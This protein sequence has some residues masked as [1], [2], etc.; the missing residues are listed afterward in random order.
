M[1]E[2]KVPGLAALTLKEG[3]IFWIGY[4]GWGNYYP[5]EWWAQKKFIC[6]SFS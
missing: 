4:Y 3:K 5:D 1:K 6:K 2:A